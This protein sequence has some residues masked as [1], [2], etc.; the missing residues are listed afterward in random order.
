MYIFVWIEKDSELLQL[1]KSNKWKKSYPCIEIYGIHMTILMAMA[2]D[3]SIPFK[4]QLCI[5]STCVFVCFPILPILRRLST[6]FLVRLT[7]ICL[8]SIIL[9][10]DI[11]SIVVGTKRD[12]LLVT[13]PMAISKN[14]VSSVLFSVLPTTQMSSM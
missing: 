3:Q 10:L 8:A 9:H 1:T 14:T 7:I 5:R 12:F 6:F 2:I 11:H 13:K 4:W